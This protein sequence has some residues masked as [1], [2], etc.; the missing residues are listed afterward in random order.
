[1]GSLPPASSSFDR[2]ASDALTMGKRGSIAA[3][4]AYWSSVEAKQAMLV[5]NDDKTQHICE[6]RASI[7]IPLREC[8]VSGW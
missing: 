1:M 7:R 2:G 3:L 5:D 8:L 6:S 4:K